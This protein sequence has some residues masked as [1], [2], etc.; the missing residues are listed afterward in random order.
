MEWWTNQQSGLIGGIGGA[1]I[2]IA[3]ALVGSLSFLIARGK[4]K[5]LMLGIYITMILIGI[6]LL[7]A[8]ITAVL[9]DQPRH[10]WYPLCLGGSIS[11]MIFGGMFPMI[12]Q[13][14]RAAEQ[15]RIEAEQL[16]RS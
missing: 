2:G 5:P 10:V 7:I 12:L 1:A 3:G 15:R 11:M 9:K 8:G 13:R 14:Y 4:G 6:S 16:R